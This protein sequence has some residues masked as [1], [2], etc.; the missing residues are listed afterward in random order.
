MTDHEFDIYMHKFRERYRIKTAQDCCRIIRGR[1]GEISPY[2]PAKELL[3][4][5]C[6]SFR[7][8]QHKT[9]VLKKLK[10][11]L[12]DV[13]Q[14]GDSEFGAYFAEKD[15]DFVC[16]AI[17]AHPRR[18]LSAAHKEKVVAALNKARTQSGNRS[19]AVVEDR[20]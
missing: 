11:V 16:K 9:W 8:K 20:N 7:S 13:H 6:T 1:F 18:F 10:S 4:I 5:W 3:G 19:I 17:K 2:D 15:L 14:D 12:I